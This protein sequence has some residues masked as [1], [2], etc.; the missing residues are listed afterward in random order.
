MDVSD[1]NN[2][3]QMTKITNYR[4]HSNGF[5]INEPFVEHV[6][7][8]KLRE[9]NFAYT[10]RNISFLRNGSLTLNFAARNL[11]VITNYKGHDPEVNT[12]A[13]A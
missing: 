9:V 13:N 11:L 3:V 12:F 6:S 8:I 4:Y 5:F 7:Y 2:P 10:F 1:P